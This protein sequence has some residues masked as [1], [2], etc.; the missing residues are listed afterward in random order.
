[1]MRA[2]NKDLLTIRKHTGLSMDEIREKALVRYVAEYDFEA[3]RKHE[4][5]ARKSTIIY[6]IHKHADKARS[7]LST[8]RIPI[9]P[10]ELAFY[11]AEL[12]EYL[13]MI[14]I[15]KQTLDE[16]QRKKDCNERIKAIEV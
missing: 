12:K 2:L 16:K 14:P 7:V 8:E 11:E 1:M 9:T 6:A 4:I 3:A 13:R 10:H 15:S 5:H